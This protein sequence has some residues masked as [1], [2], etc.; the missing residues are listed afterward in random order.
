MVT[1]SLVLLLAAALVAGASAQISTGILYWCSMEEKGTNIPA[2]T[3]SPSGP[4][5]RSIYGTYSGSPSRSNAAC[6]DGNEVSYN[7][8]KMFFSNGTAYPNGVVT[9]TV[10]PTDRTPYDIA[11]TG[12]L[13]ADNWGTDPSQ[14]L[15]PGFGRDPLFIT[16]SATG[17]IAPTNYP[18]TYDAK[19]T[20]NLAITEQNLYDTANPSMI[21]GKMFAF[22][23]YSDNLYVTVSINAS[24]FLPGNTG[25]SAGQFLLPNPALASNPFPTGLVFVGS[26]FPNG[27]SILQYAQYSTSQ[28]LSSSVGQYSCFTMLIPLRQACPYATS[29]FVRG[30]GGGGSY[31]ASRTTGAAVATVDLSSTVN[32]FFSAQFNVSKYATTATSCGANP[33]TFVNIGMGNSILDLYGS[34][35]NT[36]SL[37]RNCAA[38]TGRP[39]SPPVP[40]SP[41]PPPSPPSPR[42]DRPP[43]PHSPLPSP[44]PVP[45]APPSPSPPTSTVFTVI[46][47]NQSSRAYDQHVDCNYLWGTDPSTNGKTFQLLGLYNAGAYSYQCQTQTVTTSTGAIQ[48]SALWMKVFFLDSNLNG[49]FFDNLATNQGNIWAKLGAIA[50]PVGLSGA[51]GVPPPCGFFGMTHTSGNGTL[52]NLNPAFPYANITNN[53]M[54]TQYPADIEPFYACSANNVFNNNVTNPLYWV[55]PQS[56]SPAAFGIPDGINQYSPSGIN[57][58]MPSLTYLPEVECS[59]ITVPNAACSVPPSPPPAPTPPPPPPSPLPLLLRLAPRP[60]APP[61]PWPP[62]PPSPLPPPPSP[63]PPPACTIFVE[64]RRRFTAVTNPFSLAETGLPPPLN[65]AAAQFT[66]LFNQLYSA[67]VAAEYTTSPLFNFVGPLETPSSTT[68]YLLVAGTIT[69]PPQWPIF[70]ANF[71]ASSRMNI[72]A[73]QFGLTCSDLVWANISGCPGLADANVAFTGFPSPP[74]IATVSMIVQSA[75][76]SCTADGAG[77]MAAISVSVSITQGIANPTGMVCTNVAGG[78]VIQISFM[79]QSDSM[80][81]YNSITSS[82]GMTFF[83]F[84]ARATDDLPCNAVIGVVDSTQRTAQ[85]SCTPIPGQVA[86][87]LPVLCCTASPSPSPTPTPVPIAPTPVPIMPTPVPVAPTPVPVAPT[88]VPVAVSYPSFPTYTMWLSS[89]STPPNT[90]VDVDNVVSALCPAMNSTI[91]LVLSSY[92]LDYSKV[93]KSTQ[94]NGCAVV[95]PLPNPTGFVRVAYKFYFNLFSDD[96]AKV[97]AALN[98]EGGIR[99]AHVMCDSTMYFQTYPSP[100]INT[101]QPI[102]AATTPQWL[103]QAASATVC[104][105]DALAP[106]H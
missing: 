100:A 57:P 65:N 50:Y 18:I 68:D 38:I 16:N 10:C 51:P 79:L 40:P 71:A 26:D 59:I 37:S 49:L 98:S 46:F 45:A 28:T 102:D 7:C 81:F 5:P 32:L 86:T 56:A 42:P 17:V 20:C 62:A 60:R 11:P 103:S 48:W 104:Y 69:G 74:G 101:R 53:P 64:A 39:Q 22:K 36:Q 66:N 12:C 96:W 88:P 97:S 73:G 99:E 30:V 90:N 58:A 31:C 105:S 75:A 43:P 55:P 44:C 78:L 83:I 15:Y 94:L 35:V 72:L 29:T 77:L 6:H 106:L 3:N 19:S 67:G 82:P 27:Q 14:C 8:A 54:F 25:S 9:D 85:F 87:I 52:T 21:Y 80:A 47:L 91:A 34:M 93:M 23:D 33:T 24:G 70:L 61:L 84:N 63:S 76:T 4:S 95:T 92:G 1:R 89:P 41:P 2:N 13:T